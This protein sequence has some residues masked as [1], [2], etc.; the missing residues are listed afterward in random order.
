MLRRELADPIVSEK[1]YRTVVQVVL[2]FWSETWV[3]TSSMVQ[4]LKGV[5]VGLLRQ[6]TGYKT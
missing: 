2:L 6:G 1:F 5:L 4:N 3:L